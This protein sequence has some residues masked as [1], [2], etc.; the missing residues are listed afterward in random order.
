MFTLIGGA[1]IAGIVLYSHGFSADKYIKMKRK[2][3]FVRD[4]EKKLEGK[5][6]NE[7]QKAFNG[8]NKES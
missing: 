7:L 2:E 4:L 6:I 8:I 1:M 5:D 3:K